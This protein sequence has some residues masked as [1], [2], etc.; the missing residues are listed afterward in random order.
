MKKSHWLHAADR[1]LGL[2]WLLP[3]LVQFLIFCQFLFEMGKI[4]GGVCPYK[5]TIFVL[6]F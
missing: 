4:R 1:H 5:N 6:N 2:H 3:K